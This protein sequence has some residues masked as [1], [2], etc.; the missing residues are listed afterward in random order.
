MEE[1]KELFENVA[2]LFKQYYPELYRIY[3]SVPLCQK[4]YFGPW[5]MIVLNYNFAASTHRDR[6]LLAGSFW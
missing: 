2:K 6:S 1:N 5:A 4:K 3:D